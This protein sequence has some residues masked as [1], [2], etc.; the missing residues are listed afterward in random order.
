MKYR[1][2]KSTRKGL[3]IGL[4]SYTYE[5]AMAKQ[6]QLKRMGMNLKVMSENELLK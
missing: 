4:N 5:E 2:V 6:K 1:L 3:Q